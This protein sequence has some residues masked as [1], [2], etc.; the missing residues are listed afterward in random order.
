MKMKIILF[1]L[2]ILL[3]SCAQVEVIDYRFSVNQPVICSPIAR[4]G[5]TEPFDFDR[6]AEAK[7][8]FNG[9][10][11]KSVMSASGTSDRD[12][13]GGYVERTTTT[14]VSNWGVSNIS[15]NVS[16]ARDEVRSADGV[17]AIVVKTILPF[18]FVHTGIGWVYGA[19][20]LQLKGNVYKIDQKGIQ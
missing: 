13:G 16:S 3:C 9:K 5:D 14:S 8:S 2:P 15:S 18:N 10:R 6:Y 4:V 7:S 20:G 12:I 11:K 19:W 1:I 17:E